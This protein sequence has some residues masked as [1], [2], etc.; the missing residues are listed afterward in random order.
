MQK[1]LEQYLAH[2]K[3]YTLAIIGVYVSW[4]VGTNLDRVTKDYLCELG[5]E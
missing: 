3:L 2:C 5:P 4:E 1:G